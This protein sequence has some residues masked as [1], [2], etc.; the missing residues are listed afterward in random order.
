MEQDADNVILI[1]RPGFYESIVR[2]YNGDRDALKSTAEFIF[3]KTRFGATGSRKVK[4][5]T[6]LSLFSNRDP[7]DDY[8][9]VDDDAEGGEN[10]LFGEDV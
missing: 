3:P 8:A 10:D 9:A 2:R 4:W 5:D 6:R 7:Q 1:H